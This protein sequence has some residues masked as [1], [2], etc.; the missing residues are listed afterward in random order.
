MRW[1]GLARS[2]ATGSMVLAL[3]SCTGTSSSEQNIHSTASTADVNV[4]HGGATYYR[5]GDPSVLYVGLAQDTR[6][7]QSDCFIRY[8]TSAVW[9]GSEFDVKVAGTS[10]GQPATDGC[11]ADGVGVEYVKVQ[12]P[13]PYDGQPIKDVDT[14]LVRHATALLQLPVHH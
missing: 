10:P 1:H 5:S 4:S 11:S 9:T 14:G 13:R 12:L 3:A 6:D 7:R 2:S 8:T